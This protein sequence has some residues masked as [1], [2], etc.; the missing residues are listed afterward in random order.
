MSEPSAE[1]GEPHRGSR[2]FLV[3]LCG[4]TFLSAIVLVG[5]VLYLNT[6]PTTFP[7]GTHIAIARGASLNDISHILRKEHVI[8]SGFLFRAL[9][10]LK[11]KESTLRAGPHMFPTAMSTSDVV[12]S[13]LDGSSSIPPT[14][15]TIPEGSTLKEFDAL[16]SSAVPTIKKGSLSKEVANTEGVL[17]PDTYFIE[18][19]DT[20]SYIATLLKDTFVAKLK[21]RHDA[22]LHSGISAEEVVILASIVEKEAKDENSMKIIA[23]ILL[24]RLKNNM[25][26]QTDATFFYILGKKSSELTE[27]DLSIDSPYNLYRNK[28]LPPAPINSPGLTAI[29]A[30]LH[31]TTTDYLYYLTGTDGTFHYAKTFDEHKKNKVLYL[32]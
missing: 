26:L 16:L 5:G 10:V 17:F 13:F 8:R 15:V 4:M 28:G 11:G 14:H 1:H 18:E 7:A 31:P 25:P 29:D 6:P 32:R 24:Q 23:G 9:I 2:T 30:I 22:I 21:E 3:S 27:K 20:V 12:R 19:T